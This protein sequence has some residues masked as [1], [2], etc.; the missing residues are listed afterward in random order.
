MRRAL[1]V[2]LALVFS[3]C[4]GPSNPVIPQEATL[5]KSYMEMGV[6]LAFPGIGRL[7]AL[8]PFLVN[9][10]SPGA[11]GLTF[12]ADTSPGAPPNSYVFVLPLDGDSNGSTESVITGT[13]RLSGDPSTATVGFG[14][15]VD[16]AVTSMGGLGNFSGTFEFTMMEQGT[17]VCG[18]GA[19]V[20]NLSG[21]NT[22]ISIDAAHPLLSKPATGAAG[23][24]ANACGYSL[25]GDVKM[26]VIGP[27]GTLSSD[28]SFSSDR[29]GI[30]Q[31][32]ATHTDANG[33]VTH[34]PETSFEIPCG[35]GSIQDWVG[36]YVQDWACIPSELGQATLTLTVTGPSTIRIVDEDPPGSGDTQVYNATVLPNN[37]HILHG[38]FIAGPAGSTYREDFT[39]TLAP[40]GLSFSQV[41]LYKYQEG[42]H[43]YPGGICAGNARRVVL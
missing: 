16:V 27:M 22:N 4:G 2:A 21:N 39:W 7:D 12:Q 41:S 33:T 29:Q 17:S 1:P 37:P 3:G 40:N 5:M 31:R 30:T 23:G 20:D 10:G 25:D 8:L 28:V 24:V 15:T 35:D 13:C 32:G 9:P 18:S 36:S 19:F 26:N 42:V 14:G 43:T 6:A 38:F 11:A 34:L